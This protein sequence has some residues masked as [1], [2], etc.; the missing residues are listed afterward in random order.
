[1]AGQ[2]RKFCHSDH[3]YASKHYTDDYVLPL[4]PKHAS[5]KP[6]YNHHFEDEALGNS[7]DTPVFSSDDVPASSENYLQ[8]RSKQQRKGPWWVRR[9]E[10]HPFVVP[11]K[12]KRQFQRNMDS[13]VWMGSS[14]TD[15]EDDSEDPGSA[16]SH[17]PAEALD[18]LARETWEDPEKFEGPVFPYW[19]HQ[20]SNLP[21]FWRT[22]KEAARKIE[23]S[24]TYGS[25]IVDLS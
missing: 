25:E 1:M 18:V 10:H 3:D 5:F 19:D 17:P 2:K 6:A 14:D 15:I 7:S 24:C 8:H 20:P 22:Q 9:P 13:G 16:N 11:T 12:P 23:E 21:N 4:I